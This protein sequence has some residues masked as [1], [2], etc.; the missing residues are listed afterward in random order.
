VPTDWKKSY[1]DGYR[2]EVEIKDGLLKAK[3]IDGIMG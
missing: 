3:P 1:E 2:I